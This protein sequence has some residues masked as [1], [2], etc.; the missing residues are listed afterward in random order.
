MIAG[1]EGHSMKSLQQ[2]LER[3]SAKSTE[4]APVV[5]MVSKDL[6]LCGQ[7]EMSPATINASFR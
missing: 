4:G 5:D 2:Q 6:S 7:S 3:G 1:N